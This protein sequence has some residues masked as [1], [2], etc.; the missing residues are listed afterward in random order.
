MRQSQVISQR[1]TV[2]W[3]CELLK[4]SPYKMLPEYKQPL[5]TWGESWRVASPGETQ[6]LLGS[7]SSA[8]CWLLWR[9]QAQLLLLWHLALTH[10]VLIKLR[11]C[12]CNLSCAQLSWVGMSAVTLHTWWV[13]GRMQALAPIKVGCE[14]LMWAGRFSSGKWPCSVVTA[15]P[16]E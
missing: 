10:V 5:P 14:R 1:H 12:L 7:T 6:L 11:L 13:Q 2:F 9:P 8:E 4:S 3:R 16:W 15:R